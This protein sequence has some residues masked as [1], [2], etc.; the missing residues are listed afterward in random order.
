VGAVEDHAGELE[1]ARRSSRGEAEVVAVE[2]RADAPVVGEA[3]QE[4][5]RR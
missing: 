5:A 1:A 2:D 4:A 3:D